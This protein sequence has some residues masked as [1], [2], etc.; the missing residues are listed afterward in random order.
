VVDRSREILSEAPVKNDE[1]RPPDRVAVTI[2]P[3][4]VAEEESVDGGPHS[5]IAA[6]MSETAPDSV[7]GI[8]VCTARATSDASFT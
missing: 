1:E 8:G 7:T 3:L 2:V 4:T 6:E 5:C